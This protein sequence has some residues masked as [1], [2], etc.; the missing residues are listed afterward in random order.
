MELMVTWNN[1]RGT[2]FGDETYDN[3]LRAT[4]TMSGEERMQALHDAEHYAIAEQCW[5]CPLF[6]YG[7]VSLQKPGTTGVINNPQAN[8]IFWYVKCPE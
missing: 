8:H 1:T 7:T 3:M 6:G 4:M 5:N 2:F